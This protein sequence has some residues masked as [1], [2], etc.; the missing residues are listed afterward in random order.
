MS[1]AEAEFLSGLPLGLWEGLWV[2]RTAS[3][4]MV[5]RKWRGTVSVCSVGSKVCRPVTRIMD[6]YC[7]LMDGFQDYDQRWLELDS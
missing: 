7:S 4:T 3:M 1:V 2:G 6:R 5:E